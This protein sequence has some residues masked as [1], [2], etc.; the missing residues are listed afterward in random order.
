MGRAI[1]LALALEFLFGEQAV[2]NLEESGGDRGGSS[3]PIRTSHRLQ[4]RTWGGGWATA[5]SG[6]R[7]GVCGER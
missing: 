6:G 4:S 7:F 5:T 2:L 3:R 1:I